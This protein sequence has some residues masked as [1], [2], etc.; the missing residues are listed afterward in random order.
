[1]TQPRTRRAHRVQP[2]I[3]RTA[4]PVA[5][6]QCPNANATFRI[7][8]CTLGG[9]TRN[10]FPDITCLHQPARVSNQLKL[11]STEIL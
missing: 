2:A 11:T 1:M 7:S 10:R 9:C 6:A 5:A 8:G 3:M 4:V